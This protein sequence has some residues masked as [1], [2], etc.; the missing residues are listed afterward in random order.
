MGRART[1]A[2][3]T[4]L[5]GS[6]TIAGGVAFGVHVYKQADM[7]PLLNSL[8]EGEVAIT[9]YVRIDASG[10]TL[11]TPHADLGQ[12]AYS[13]QAALIAEELDVDLDQII[14]DP[15]PP[16]PVY[17]NTV[18]A[19]EALPLA[20]TDESSIAEWMRSFSSVPMKLLGV[21]ITGGSSTVP[22][23]YEKLRVAGAVARETLKLA[24]S[25]K[26]GV[27]VDQLTTR[28]GKV[29]AYGGDEI[30]YL[31]LAEEAA[32]IELASEVVL[33]EPSQWRHL[34]KPM[35]RID[36]VAKTTGS[37]KYGIDLE[38]EN[39]VHATVR[40]APGQTGAVKSFDDSAA[41]EMRGV[42]D[43]IAITGGLAV[44][45]DN[46]WRAFQAADALKIEWEPQSFPPD[47]DGHWS[48]LSDSFSNKR[49]N[50][51][52]RD[53]GD[54]EADLVND[55]VIVAEYRAPYVAH[56]PLE[57]LC[58]I[59]LVTDE[60]A[61]VWTATQIPGFVQDQVA[62]ISGIDFDDV[63]VH[64]QMVGGSFGNRLEAAY[65]YQA[66]EIAVALKGT[67]VKLTYSREEDFRQDFVRQIA[68][69]RLRGRVADG[70]VETFDL[71]IAMPSTLASQMGR[72]PLPYLGPG[73]L[74]YVGPDMLIVAGSW[75]LPYAIPNHRVSG[76]RAPEIVPVSWW[77]SVG[78][79]TNGFFYDCALDE[80]IHAAGADP[81]EERIRLINHD[82]SRKVLEAVGEMSNWGSD[83]GENRGR[84]IAY[85]LAFGV[86]TA[87][88]IEVTN[89]ENGIRIDK[90]FVAAEVG[91]ILDPV[92]LEAQLS[93][94]VIW[95]LGHAMNCEMTYKHG[96]AEQ[97][98][99]HVHEG[100][101]LYQCPEIEVRGLENG[102]KI[103]GVGEA[104]VPPA[105]PA[106]ANA[107]FAATGKRI[108]ELPF[109]RHIDFV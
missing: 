27:G 46:T 86:A 65:V 24:A 78:A 49:R 33:R 39:M 35:Q 4:F 38:I 96:V 28:S 30:S 54:V 69:G 73:K 11:I 74:P 109:N 22:N 31:E 40:M 25:R 34:G 61:D 18:V 66:T 82:D 60:R 57:P 1:I 23:T 52:F 32:A 10:I 64:V 106:L 56:A 91:R 72:L 101:R 77:R 9:P 85:C 50:S 104:P 37:L 43:V 87:E 42:K 19:P 17:A 81:L 29:V 79:S 88:V 48:V 67:A 62:R 5:I 97:T 95:G 93:G 99:Y 83:L 108:R 102:E 13:I 8:Q 63:H 100:M 105:A 6:A 20:A 70:K 84:G 80:L 89:T 15:G 47:M 44:I 103:R 36:V 58:A 98:N 68:M 71:G 41:R 94:G 16:S 75:D 7:N 26:L 3:R 21:Q 2:R 45:A 55:D 92:N 53:E 14:V 12:G 76:Y 59:V 107:I 51:R 90:V